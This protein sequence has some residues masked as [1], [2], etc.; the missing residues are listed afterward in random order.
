[1]D[2][3]FPLLMRLCF[4]SKKN[5]HQWPGMFRHLSVGVGS[6]ICSYPR[7]S[8]LNVFFFSLCTLAQGQ[9]SCSRLGRKW[10]IVTRNIWFSSHPAET[11]YKFVHRDMRQ[12]WRYTAQIP[13]QERN[14]CRAARS[15]VHWHPPAVRF[16]RFASAWDHVILNP[17]SASAWGAGR[18]V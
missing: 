8:S 13:L 11:R 4:P 3:L 10:S 18:R 1:M 7:D 16:S 2:N 5:W 6:S 17:S 9:L 14:C 12:T 15:V